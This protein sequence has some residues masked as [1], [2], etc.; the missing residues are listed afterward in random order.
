MQLYRGKK[1]GLRFHFE[2]SDSLDLSGAEITRAACIFGSF[3][4]HLRTS[5]HASVTIVTC[6]V[7]MKMNLVDEEQNILS[8]D[9]LV[10]LISKSIC[11]CTANFRNLVCLVYNSCIKNRLVWKLEIVEGI[12]PTQHAYKKQMLCLQ[13]LVRVVNSVTDAKKNQNIIL[14]W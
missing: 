8:V 5:S 2:I 3:C 10:L 6:S 11:A 14:C 1:L 4:L 13:A 12:A 7:K 9:A